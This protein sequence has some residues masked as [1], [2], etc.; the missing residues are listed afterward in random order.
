MTQRY[1]PCADSERALPSQST[2]CT[3]SGTCATADKRLDLG[4]TFDGN[5]NIT[6]ITDGVNGRQTR[7]MAYDGLDRLTQVTSNM[8]G[9]ASYGYD[10]LDNLAHVQLTG[11]Q[12]RDRYY[13]CSGLP[14]CASSAWNCSSTPAGRCEQELTTRRRSVARPWAARV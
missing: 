9:T 7:G 2:D 6:H 8:F 12:A 4:Y 5:G 10:V 3:A 13:C 14:C 1:C 11:G